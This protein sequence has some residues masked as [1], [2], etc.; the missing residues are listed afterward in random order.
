MTRA[1]YCG[2]FLL[3][4]SAGI[5]IFLGNMLGNTP[6]TG[7]TDF[8]GVY[9]ATRCLLSHD[10]P[11][12]AAELLRAYQS[13]GGDA[14]SLSSINRQI[15]SLTNYIPTTFILIVP[16]AMLPWNPATLLWTILTAASLLLVAILMW[17]IGVSKA[18][19]IT[20]GLICV[21]LAN[22]EVLFAL[23]NPAGV[24]VGL[25]VVA[26]WCFIK[27]RLVWAGVLCLAVS[28]ALKP[29]DAGLVWLYFLLAG[30]TYRRYALQTLLVIVLLAL[31]ALLWVSHVAPHWQR[32]MYS[33][34]LTYSMRGNV[35]D[36][37][38]SSS[39]GNTLFEVIDLQTAI[40]VFKD[41]PRIYN[42]ISYLVCGALLFVWPVT[43]LRTRF[44]P[45]NA[46]IALAAVSALTML[47]T[48]HRPY[49]AKIL[50]LTI[51]ACAMLW[52]GGGPIGRL[53]LLVNTAGVVFTS[54]IPLEI[55]VI[56][57]K[58]LHLSTTTLTGQI[59][60]VLLMRPVPLILLV[61]GIFYLWVYV[62]RASVPGATADPAD[63]RR[64]SA[65]ATSA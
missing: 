6:Q 65:E 16:M 1:R 41:N 36:P 37:G 58:N 12:K 39:T 50:L 49:D 43:T 59:L 18:P 29:H 31:P 35:N 25:C 8:R 34:L 44:S 48:Y 3:L 7:F 45:A 17:S 32:E 20:V 27:E 5:S 63:S 38:P 4:L 26:A 40:S 14:A 61:M 60:T 9:Y 22:S 51:P 55:L 53:A 52:A 30:K 56:L 57:T 24:A 28:L 19:V 13:D 33:N 21:V 64:M 15:L 11:Y 62:R 42:E 47:V 2:L 23:G 46:W 54:D 10:D